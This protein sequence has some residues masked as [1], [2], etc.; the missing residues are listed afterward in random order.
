M[1]EARLIRR[2]KGHM[3]RFI[4][5]AKDYD[6]KNPIEALAG[7]GHVVS[8]AGGIDPLVREGLGKADGSTKNGV[9]NY[10]G[11]F[12]YGGKTMENIA[13]VAGVFKGQFGRALGG[14]IN[15]LPD[16]ASDGMDAFADVRHGEKYRQAA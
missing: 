4:E 15:V 2:Y 13:S 11:I 7:A 10:E 5:T 9:G 6:Y 14:V 8:S 3:N 1:K 16:A 12:G